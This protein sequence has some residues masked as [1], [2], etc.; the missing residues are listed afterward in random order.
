MAI[1]RDEKSMKRRVG[2]DKGERTRTEMC[3]SEEQWSD[4]A[5]ST[6]E[7]ERERK[8]VLLSRTAST[9]HFVR[10]NK[11]SSFFH[12][13]CSHLP[14]PSSPSFNRG[15]LLKSC[16]LASPSFPPP[17]PFF[18]PPLLHPKTPIIPFLSRS[19]SWKQLT[20]GKR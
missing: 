14:P 5:S 18:L 20:R 1:G 2:E 13:P 3:I 12:P 17:M 7:R 15:F 4:R 10:L 16:L 19:R 6:G 11:A 9:P 8:I